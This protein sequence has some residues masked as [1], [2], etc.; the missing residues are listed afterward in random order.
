MKGN[1]IKFYCGHAGIHSQDGGITFTAGLTAITSNDGPGWGNTTDPGGHTIHHYT[2]GK[3]GNSHNTGNAGGN[4]GSHTS[5]SEDDLKSHPELQAMMLPGVPMSLAVISGG[6]GTTLNTSSSVSA[7]MDEALARLGA[8]AVDALPYAG[9]LAGMVVGML[10]PSSLSGNDMVSVVDT[11]PA[12]LLTKETITTQPAVSTQLRIQDVIVDGKQQLALVKPAPAQSQVKVVQATATSRPGV[13]TASVVPGKPALTIKIDISPAKNVTP[14]S[15]KTVT[16]STPA[17]VE[18]LHAVPGNQTHDAI[19]SFPV[20]SHIAPIYVTVKPALPQKQLDEKKQQLAAQQAAWDKQ[21]PGEALQMKLKLARSEREVCDKALAASKV[22]QQ[23]WMEE[24]NR[25]TNRAKSS[26]ATI[27]QIA[28]ETIEKFYQALAGKMTLAQFTALYDEKQKVVTTLQGQHKNAQADIDHAQLQLGTITARIQL[29]NQALVAAD[30]ALPPLLQQ[31]RDSANKQLA[32]ANVFPLRGYGSNT[33]PGFSYLGNGYAGPTA[34]QSA[35]YAQNLLAAAARLKPQPHGDVSIT[36]TGLELDTQALWQSGKL[37]ST[38]FSQ[39]FLAAI[40]PVVIGLTDTGALRAAVGKSVNTSL[41][42]QLAVYAGEAFL[43]LV[44]TQT[45]QPLRVLAATLDPQSDYYQFTLPADIAAGQPQILVSPANA[46]GV[47]GPI[48]LDGPAPLPSAFIHTGGNIISLP[49]LSATVLPLPTVKSWRD[50]ILVFPDGSGIQPLYVMLHS[51]YGESDTKGRYS[52]RDYHSEKCGG[53]VVDLDWRTANI[54]AA[55]IE[56]V[57]IHVKRFGAS[58]GND[59]M[60][61]RLA[62]IAGGKLVATDTDKRFYTH[63]IRELE[64]YRALGCADSETDDETW[65]NTHS[66]TLEDYKLADDDNNLYTKEAL[67]AFKKEDME[68][69]K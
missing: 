22:Q 13:F 53:P 1:R 32:G 9:R 37:N 35:A 33:P 67:D 39:V 29:E 63:E 26:Q 48:V 42:G 61:Q 41:R 40:S 54:D 62:D 21:H 49:A 6:W 43:Q 57:K 17:S 30:R 46:P 60:V 44:R 27:D 14:S 68:V 56:L 45:P 34:A 66:A 5:S 10:I 19:I 69:E 16:A 52:N 7:A 59:V 65:N 11:L 20:G 8:L 3:G 51:P 64:R 38:D 25:A 12:G 58:V 15:S 23:R 24:L 47:N 55:G 31:L 4:G 36:T 18:L 50:F 28:A 2:G